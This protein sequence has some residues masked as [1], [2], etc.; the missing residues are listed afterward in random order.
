MNLETDFILVM[1]I[2]G[3]KNIQISWPEWNLNS[4]LQCEG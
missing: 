1:A 4:I 2:F 3:T